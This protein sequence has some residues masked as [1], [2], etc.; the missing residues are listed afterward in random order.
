MAHHV[1]VAAEPAVVLPSRNGSSPF[2]GLRR[3]AV[4]ARAAFW[5]LQA[6]SLA[7][8][9]LAVLLRN[10]TDRVSLRLTGL[11]LS[12]DCRARALGV[13]GDFCYDIDDSRCSLADQSCTSYP[14][15]ALTKHRRKNRDKIVGALGVLLG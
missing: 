7:A 14:D 6:K 8:E 11:S 1:D 3:E 5:S 10:I 9:R 13:L 2:F 15:R 12:R 4:Q